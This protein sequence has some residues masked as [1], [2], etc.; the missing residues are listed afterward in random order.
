M[1]KRNLAP[2]DQHEFLSWER[3][4]K[5]GKMMVGFFIMLF[6]TL[7]LLREMGLEIHRSIFY[8]SSI[9]IAVGIILLVRHK[10]R[11][12]IGFMLIAIGI[13]FKVR[14]HFPDLINWNLIFPVILILIGAA[15]VVKA[16]YGRQIK[17]S[18][19]D[20]WQE[21]IDSMGLDLEEIEPDDFVDGVSIF[22]GIKRKVTSKK[23]KGAD[24]FTIFGGTEL[25]MMQA[26]FENKAIIEMTT[27]MGGA[28]II[29]PADWQVRTEIVTVFG[30][31][32]DNRYQLPIESQSEKILIIRG[33]C[34]LGGVEIKSYSV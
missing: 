1:E 24:L 11:K 19:K 9:M 21:Q 7:F 18:K 14:H 28:E 31:V 10:F 20:D 6:G 27:L 8:P 23:F 13:F 33:T 2:E 34:V 26:D 25:N 3:G 30:G 16:R 32:D 4:K 17:R 15:M 5:R 22:G 12:P 29:V